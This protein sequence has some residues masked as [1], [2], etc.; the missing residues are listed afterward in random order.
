MAIS[1]LR[2][3]FSELVLLYVC[4]FAGKSTTFVQNKLED[5]ITKI[6]EHN[7]S[8]NWQDFL[9]QAEK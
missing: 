6:I 2:V 3:I 7:E 9:S 1:Y 5:M 8:D 4:Y